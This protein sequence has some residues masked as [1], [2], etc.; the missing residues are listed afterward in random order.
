MKEELQIHY[1]R[2]FCGKRP[3]Y[4]SE[5]YFNSGY[6]AHHTEFNSLCLTSQLCGIPFP[7]YPYKS[8]SQVKASTYGTYIVRKDTISHK[9]EITFDLRTIP[10]T[11]SM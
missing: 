5:Y 9:D 1:I 7:D 6:D 2:D 8:T 11:R 4:K 10:I 3:L